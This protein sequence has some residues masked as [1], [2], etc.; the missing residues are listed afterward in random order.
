MKKNNLTDGQRSEIALACKEAE[1]GILRKMYRKVNSKQAKT[2]IV[3]K[4]LGTTISKRTLD[5]EKE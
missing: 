4:A 3:D 2:I 1:L 5:F